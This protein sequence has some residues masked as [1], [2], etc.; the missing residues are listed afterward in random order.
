MRF[1]RY[2][3]VTETKRTGTLAWKVRGVWNVTW[4]Y[5]QKSKYYVMLAWGGM[6]RKSTLSTGLVLHRWCQWIQRIPSPWRHPQWGASLPFTCLY[7]SLPPQVWKSHLSYLKDTS[8]MFWLIT[9]LRANPFITTITIHWNKS[10]F[11]LLPCVFLLVWDKTGMRRLYAKHT[12]AN[13]SHL[14]LNKLPHW[15]FDT[16]L[17]A[18][19]TFPFN[20]S[21]LA[22]GTVASCGHYLAVAICEAEA[23]C[24]RFYPKRSHFCCCWVRLKTPLQ[25]G[26]AAHGLFRTPVSM[27]WQLWTG[28][29]PPEKQQAREKYIYTSLFK[30]LLVVSHQDK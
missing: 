8:N 17:G 26:L 15:P 4:L 13:R 30:E 22:V 2:T 14:R 5:S 28:N 12:A 23:E 18:H 1:P 11:S 6:R 9:L 27:W 16:Q 3:K 21:P 29:V 24:S 25:A 10:N 7:S 20:Q 19:E